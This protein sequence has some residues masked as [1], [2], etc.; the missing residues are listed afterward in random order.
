MATIVDQFGRPIEAAK[1][2]DTDRFA[3]ATVFDRWST[4]PSRGLT[5]E[6]LTAILTEADEGDVVRQCELGSEIEEKDAHVASQLQTRRLAVLGLDREVLPTGDEDLSQRAADLCNEALERLD[7]DDLLGDLLDAVLQGWSCSEILWETGTKALPRAVVWI[8]PGRFLWER[9]VIRL[10]TDREPV[11]GEILPANKF[12]LHVHKAR[13]GLPARG[14]LLRTVAWLYLFKNWSV[15][16][17][18]AY[19]ETYGMPIRLGKYQPGTP[20]EE[21]DKLLSALVSIAS[22]AAG[23]I[24]NTA[25]IQFVEAG[26]QGGSSGDVFERMAAWCERGISKAI[27]GQTLT[28]D[29]TGA[30]GTFAAGSVHNEVRHD[31]TEADAKALAK[32]VRRD[33]F[34][35]VVG[36]NLGWDVAE[37]VLP[38]LRFDVSQPEDQEKKAR[39]YSILRRDVGLRIGAAH[40]REKFGIPEPGKDEELVGE[41][42]AVTPPPPAPEKLALKA[43]TP[44]GAQ[45][46][47]APAPATADPVQALVDGLAEAAR[48]EGGAAMSKMAEELTRLVA[49][50]KDFDELRDRVLAAYSQMDPAELQDVLARAM[51]MADLGGRANA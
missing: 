41:L 50:A 5:P 26:K 32:T 46:H 1:R 48:Q 22:N 9:Q 27:L 10:R 21:V 42:A 19:L 4:Y 3:V 13:S 8:E 37:R 2:P 29:T 47:K 31:L 34:R 16:D 30:T 25:D 24:P 23:V 17:W 39:T 20:K 43:G 45:A 12:I 38:L 35:P 33:L 6:R 28:S 7:G 15:K 49:D 11:R 18:S 36:F 51:A 40:V 44:T 14:G